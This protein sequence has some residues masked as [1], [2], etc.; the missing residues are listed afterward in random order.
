MS[1]PPF[2]QER[3]VKENSGNAGT[4][5]EEW[6][7]R[8]GSNVRNVGY[9][10]RGIHRWVVRTTVDVPMDEQAEEHAQPAEARDDGEDP[11]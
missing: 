7:E 4:S 6:F 8:F 2:G 11:V 10:L 1:Q 5:D 3:K 9:G